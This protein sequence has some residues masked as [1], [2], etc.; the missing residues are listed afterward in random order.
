[1]RDFQ[2]LLEK[3]VRNFRGY[4]KNNTIHINLFVI[5]FLSLYLNKINMLYIYTYTCMQKCTNTHTNIEILIGICT[6]KEIQ[7]RSR[8]CLQWEENLSRKDR[9]IVANLTRLESSYP[10]R[11]PPL[12]HRTGCA[13]L[14]NYS[15]FWNSLLDGEPPRV[16]HHHLVENKIQISGSNC[17]FHSLFNN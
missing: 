5:Y 14:G 7:T 16:P 9:Q 12:I 3:I 8:L 17:S 2:L 10:T 15:F 11:K 6:Y 4:S 13:N 1:M